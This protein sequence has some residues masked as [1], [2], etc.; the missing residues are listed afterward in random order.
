MAETVRDV[1][2]QIRLAQLDAKL[3]APDTRL[4]QQAL[5][6]YRDDAAQTAKAVADSLGTI[7]VS[8]GGSQELSEGFDD[9]KKSASA[10]AGDIETIDSLLGS[11]DAE[12]LSLGV[13]SDSISAASEA[14]S[15]SAAGVQD[16]KEGFQDATQSASALA[17]G[18][19]QASDMVDSFDLSKLD[20][21]LKPPDSGKLKK[22]LEDYRKE[23]ETTGKGVKSAFDIA[24][25]AIQESTD[26]VAALSTAMMK[27]KTDSDAAT[28]TLTDN[29]LRAG[30]GFKAAGEGAFTLARGVAFM[31]TGSGEE[32]D[33]I[34]KKIAKVQ[35]AFDLFKGSTETIKGLIEGS[36][37]LRTVTAGVAVANTAQATTGAVVATTN[38]AVATTGAAA[39][40][41][42]RALMIS[43][44]PLAIGLAAVAAAFLFFSESEEEAEEAADRMK[45]KT[46]E[47][48]DEATK[49][50]AEDAAATDARIARRNTAFQRTRSVE[51]RERSDTAEL[52]RLDN[53]K[54]E[55]GLTTKLA[56]IQRQITSE[57]E[58]TGDL[59]RIRQ[60]AQTRGEDQ[61]GLDVLAE[62]KSRAEDIQKSVSAGGSGEDELSR[63]VKSLTQIEDLLN[64]V[65]QSERKRLAVLENEGSQLQR[66]L[67]TQQSALEA[68]KKAL[69]LET[70]KL[71]TL[72]EISGRLDPAKRAVLEQFG[73]RVEAGET[74]SQADLSTLEGI[75]GAGVSDF[76]SEEFQRR[77]RE[78]GGR[79]LFQP[80]TDEQLTGDDSRQQQLQEQTDAL[81][82][83]VDEIVSQIEAIGQQRLEQFGRIRDALLVAMENR[84]LLNDIEQ[85]LTD[86]AQQ[87]RSRN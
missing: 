45:Q 81:Q 42:M 59:F 7:G 87:N 10:L 74:L 56:S 70:Q 29:S 50:A 75:G 83:G 58:K 64:S 68:S 13:D 8:T 47:L 77:G 51:A 85:K 17:D 14:I 52:A 76:V 80:F 2:I 6:D 63:N 62:L 73:K 15:D 19:E 36:R 55:V 37:A 34:V 57:V 11:L 79:E 43:L 48:A 32:M 84:E 25:D 26:E 41:S 65:E 49:F 66:N 16:L 9:A 33:K 78:A 28:A 69:E 71:Q 5:A 4:L 21:D 1:V 40:T 54:N 72:D 46:K 24:T 3:K 23:A 44:G 31:S 60:G 82:T 30:E 20:T 39:A 22:W 18:I 27:A 61:F 67:S 86:A 38:T 12:K 53:L 35:G